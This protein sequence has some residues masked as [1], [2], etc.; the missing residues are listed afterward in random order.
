[1]KHC[2]GNFEIHFT[3]PAKLY[4]ELSSTVLLSG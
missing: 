2:F 1:L 4:L 3:G